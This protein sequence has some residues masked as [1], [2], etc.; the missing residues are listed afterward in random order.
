MES[1]E[2]FYTAAEV[3]PLFG[4]TAQTV[5]RWAQVGKIPHIKTPMGKQYRFPRKE[6]DELCRARLE[7]G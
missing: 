5:C 4:V 1:L 7:E 2:E 3:A 6:V